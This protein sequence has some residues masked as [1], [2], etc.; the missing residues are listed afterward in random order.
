MI[1]A[2]VVIERRRQNRESIKTDLDLIAAIASL[3]YEL[4]TLVLRLVEAP[5]DRA[6]WHKYLALVLWQVLE[7]LPSLLGTDLQDEGKN[8]KNAVKGIRKDRAFMEELKQ[9]RNGVA[10]HLSLTKVGPGRVEWSF[11]SIV[12]NALGEP[13]VLTTLVMRATEVSTAVHQL[14]SSL[15][16]KHITLFPGANV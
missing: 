6:I 11:D 7:E 9:I 3:N 13:A 1:I 15:I 5:S 8:F 12:N 2:T 10:A 16:R 14:G 4:K